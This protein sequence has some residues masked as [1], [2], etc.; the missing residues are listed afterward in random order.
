MANLKINKTKYNTYYR[1]RVYNVQGSINL[2][3]SDK[4]EYCAIAA[5]K[6]EGYQPE[7]GDPS[8]TWRESN[9]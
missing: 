8:A 3:T 1:S 5:I 4:D 9:L 7:P 6:A 2:D